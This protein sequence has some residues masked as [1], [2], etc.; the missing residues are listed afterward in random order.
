MKRFYNKSLNVLKETNK[1][2][3]DDIDSYVCYLEHIQAVLINEISQTP[4]TCSEI[5]LLEKLGYGPGKKGLV[6][7]SDGQGKE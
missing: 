1:E 2:L 5:L 6:G 7:R 4:S 3:A